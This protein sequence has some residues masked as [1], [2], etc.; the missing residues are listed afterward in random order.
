VNELYIL[1][2]YVIPPLVRES[3][4]VRDLTMPVLG[5][6]YDEPA[7]KRNPGYVTHAKERNSK[8]KVRSTVSYL[9]RA[10]A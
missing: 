6:E 3:R 4:L 2:A 10:Q 8:R 7:Y 9:L 1:G 5:N